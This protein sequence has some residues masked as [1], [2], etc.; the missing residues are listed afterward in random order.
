M[1][2]FDDVWLRDVQEIVQTL[3]VFAAPVGIARAT[4]GRLV[5]LVLLDHR[6]HRAV[7]D[8]DALT[9]Q[10][11][12]MFDSARHRFCL[13]QINRQKINGKLSVM[14]IINQRIQI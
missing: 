3:E 14:Q 12:K 6:A 8:D 5:Q 2:P 4:E 9:Q 10:A 1:D 7:N 13:M 11:L